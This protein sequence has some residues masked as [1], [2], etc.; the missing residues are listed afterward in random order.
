M[1]DTV[2]VTLTTH[3]AK[4]LDIADKYHIYQKTEKKNIQINGGSVINENK[5]FGVVVKHDPR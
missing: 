1:E 4:H 5:I 3:K 2:D